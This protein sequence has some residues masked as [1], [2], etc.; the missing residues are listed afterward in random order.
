MCLL[1]SPS[2]S[3][4]HN[5]LASLLAF[6]QHSSLITPFRILFCIY[7]RK[8]YLAILYHHVG[9]YL[10]NAD[11]AKGTFE[12]EH[13][14]LD[15]NITSSERSVAPRGSH[16]SPQSHIPYVVSSSS[17]ALAVSWI[18]NDPRSSHLVFGF[19][20]GVLKRFDMWGKLEGIPFQSA[21]NRDATP[22]L[23][24]NRCAPCLF[25]DVPFL[26]CLSSFLLLSSSSLYSPLFFLFS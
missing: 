2:V 3:S 10:M 14:W 17:S 21:R 20:S 18:L 6:T 19:H 12:N 9:V 13:S 8:D 11:A 4:G 7:Y 15:G 22:G 16:S 25:S 26:V 1:P 5:L 23:D 24:G